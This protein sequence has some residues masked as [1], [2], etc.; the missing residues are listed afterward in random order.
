MNNK[1]Q[2]ILTFIKDNNILFIDLRFTDSFGS[3]Q[4][5]TIPVSSC[6]EE[7]FKEGLGLDGSSIRGFQSIEKSD[8][9]IIPDLNSFF[10]DPFTVHATGVFICDVYTPDLERYQKDPRFI[11]Q[12]AEE[13]LKQTGIA[14][15]V[16]FGPECEFFLFDKLTYE[17]HPHSTG[18]TIDSQ[19]APWNSS[20][21]DNSGPTLRTK[22]GYFPCFPLDR[23]QN[24]RSEMMVKLLEVGIGSEM[25]HHEVAASGQ[26]EL[27]IR[28]NTLQTVSDHLQ[29]YKYIVRNTAAEHGLI[30][31]FMPKP[32]YG[33]NG[34]GM[35]M[36]MSLW[37]NNESLM[38][39]KGNYGDLSDVARWMIGGILKH[40]SVLLAFCAPTTNSY[41]RLVPGYEAPINLIYSCQNR[42]ACIRIPLLKSNP[43]AKRIE[44]RAPDPSANPYLATAA[45]LMAA[46][47]G[48]QNKIEPIL[49]Q[50]V[51]FY[52]LSAED[53]KNI[54]QTPGSLR[55]VLLQLQS[56]PEFL[57]K[58]GVFTEEFIQSYVS[59]K[60][61]HECDALDLRP[62]PYEF[63]MYAD[64]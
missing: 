36:N 45:C 53:K 57:L 14:D 27:N 9:L 38:Y 61:K 32:I 12:K 54:P 20:K 21:Q 18:Y 46:L 2:E 39:Q 42:S 56:N 17:N 25:H 62:H 52:G 8:L 4:H 26:C 60:L 7:V 3:W 30:A 50:D 5:Y 37:K 16:Y 11:A 55:E 35:H 13:Y 28:Y 47:D 29:M 63:Y 34:S 58:G 51:D 41:R 44:F 59:Y 40:T 48:I 49:P 64:I 15:T 19:E 10:V 31:N 22:G 23:L 33:D 24:V 43:N 1:I 6:K